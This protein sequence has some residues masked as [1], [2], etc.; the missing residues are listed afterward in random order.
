GRAGLPAP[1]VEGVRFALVRSRGRDA[2]PVRSVMFGAALTVFVLT[3]SFTYSSSLASL[4]GHPSLYGW[5]FNTLLVTSDTTTLTPTVSP[6]MA[7]AFNSDPRVAAWSRLL[8]TSSVD[9]DGQ[10]V[11]LML[12]PPRSR[13]SPPLLSGHEIEAIHQVLVGPETLAAL[14]KRVGDEVTAS[15]G[16]AKLRV[17]IVGTA[18]FPATGLGGTLHPALGVGALAWATIV[19]SALGPIKGCG[20]EAN[21]IAVRFRAGVSARAARAETR[22]LAAVANR[23]FASL[24][25]TSPCAG[26]RFAAAGLQRP[27]EIVNYRSMGAT[28]AVVGATLTGASLVAL[29][30]ALVASVRRRRRDL[31]VFKSLG[32]TRRQ[33]AATIAWQSTITMIVG[34]VVGVPTGVVAGRWM[35][36]SFANVIH[37]VPRVVVPWLTIGVVV[38]VAL[39]V[40]NVAAAVP[41]WR[42]AATEAAPGLRAE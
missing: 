41:A 30:V 16:G 7:A 28:P 2:V 32:F 11:P 39:V 36:T 10:P 14:H 15:S 23:G 4:V 20:G 40:A 27:A 1:A 31:A 17:R 22:H 3:A 13:V 29:A 37:V 18:T 8:F 21:E 35:W 19:G 42:A 9:V 34:V 25:V 12:E 5:N 33:I 38:V 6:A 26:D 24:P